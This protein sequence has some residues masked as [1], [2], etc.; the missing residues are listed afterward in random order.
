MNVPIQYAN[1]LSNHEKAWQRFCS[2]LGTSGLTPFVG[3]DSSVGM[4]FELQVAVEGD[5]KDV[6]L[7]T[8]IGSSTYFKNVVKRSARG[9]L[10]STSLQ[11]LK[12]FLHKNNS[13][14]W[15]NSWVRFPENR[16]TAWTKKLLRPG[17]QA[18]FRKSDPT[19]FPDV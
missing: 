18:V 11:S 2:A 6:D 3:E 8:T 16:L 15:E 9:D 5:Y 4:E 14:V 7:P 13:N 12:D 19:V 10:P 1:A 17:G